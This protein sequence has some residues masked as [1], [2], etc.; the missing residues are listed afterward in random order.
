MFKFI[1]RFFL[2]TLLIALPFAVFSSETNAIEQNKP[3]VVS[4]KQTAKIV[5]DATTWIA[6]NI[7]PLDFENQLMFLNLL[8]VS[9]NPTE[10]NIRSAM[11]CAQAIQ[12]SPLMAAAYEKFQT[13]IVQKLQDFIL[14][15]EEKLNKQNLTP[16]KKQKQYGTLDKKVYELFMFINQIYYD[17]LYKH[18]KAQTKSNLTYMFDDKGLIAPAKRTRLLPIPA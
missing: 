11:T 14:L 12:E 8:A 1:Q 3:L 13:N 16:E 6:N 9:I 7:S 17:L 15:V 18:V 4:Q 10:E 5:T 2:L